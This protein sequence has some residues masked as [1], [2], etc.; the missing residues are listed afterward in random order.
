MAQAKDQD[1][2]GDVVERVAEI[3]DDLA[4]PEQALGLICCIFLPVGVSVYDIGCGGHQKC[5][6][7]ADTYRR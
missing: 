4:Q 5:N 2:H 1:D 7:Y 6:G 3:G